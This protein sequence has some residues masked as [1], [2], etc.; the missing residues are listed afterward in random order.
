MGSKSLVRVL[1]YLIEEC[2]SFERMSPE[3]R[4]A[5]C[6][7]LLENLRDSRDART[8]SLA[9]PLVDVITALSACEDVG[10]SLHGLVQWSYAE[11]DVLD[12]EEEDA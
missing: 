9:A 12:R 10:P 5:V 8:R 7:F 2:P 4:D 1:R 6:N 11:H 3:R